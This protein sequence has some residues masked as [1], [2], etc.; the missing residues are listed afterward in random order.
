VR[1]VFNS[2]HQQQAV[3]HR[4]KFN[5]M[6]LDFRV[7]TAPLL[8]KAPSKKEPFCLAACLSRSRPLTAMTGPFVDAAAAAG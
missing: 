6:D 7:S 3:L 1:Q 4:I 2:T 8:C 5:G